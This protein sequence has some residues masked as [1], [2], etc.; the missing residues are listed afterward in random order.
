MISSIPKGWVT[1]TTSICNR[2]VGY[3]SLTEEGEIANLLV[4]K[5][6]RSLGIGEELVRKAI[7][8]AKDRGIERVFAV[9]REE[10]AVRL[11]E[12]MNF[13]KEESKN[14]YDERNYIFSKVL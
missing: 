11:F 7:D 9:T 14:T 6:Y 1:L 4:D 8:I 10:K 5:D 13:Y 2:P 3:V 12:K